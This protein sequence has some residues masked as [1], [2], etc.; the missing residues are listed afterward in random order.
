MIPQGEDEYQPPFDLIFVLLISSLAIVGQYL[1]TIMLFL[2]TGKESLSIVGM[3]MVLGYGTATLLAATRIQPP[4][5][6]WLGFVPAPRVAWLTAALLIPVAMIASELD[7][8]IK[9]LA[10]LPPPEET[11]NPSGFESLELAM[12]LVVITPAVYEIFYRG[13][14]QPALVRQIGA[15][16]GIGVLAAIS[17]LAWAVI[18]A[19]GVSGAEFLA[20]FA[21]SASLALVLSLLRHCSGSLW[22]CLALNASIGAISWL[23][24]H[25]AFGIP[26]FD[27]ISAAHTP[28]V[29]LAP[30][31]A[32]V[33]IGLGL[34][35]AMV[36][37]VGSAE[38]ERRRE[39]SESKEDGE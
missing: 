9:A 24:S 38:G 7:N 36:A 20:M 31:A 12:L 26:G 19:G 37:Q 3:G 28:L 29:W 14:L 30:A 13:V 39:Q 33:G 1:S 8:V 25:S 2:L 6:A 27:D 34:C 22:P 16:G 32:S 18:A 17:G 5:E 21:Q 11:P 15:A 10:S 4:P 23:A 35:R